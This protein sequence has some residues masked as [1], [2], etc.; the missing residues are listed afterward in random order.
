MKIIIKDNFD[1]ETV[2]EEILAENV[3]EFWAHHLEELL[4]KTLSGD[5]A[6]QF[7]KAVPDDYK[8]YVYNP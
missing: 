3:N 7:F 6:Q 1:R 2:S 4:N 5:C 8:L